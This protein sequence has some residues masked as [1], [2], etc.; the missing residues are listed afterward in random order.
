MGAPT[1]PV[2]PDAD[3]D[4]EHPIATAW[5]PLFA[6]VV[7]ALVRRDPT[8]LDGLPWLSPVSPATWEQMVEYVDD[9]GETLVALDERTW[10]TSV[11]QW[12]GDHWEV[13]V[14]LVTAE[15]GR[16]DMVLHAMVRDD[17]AGIAIETCCV[18]VP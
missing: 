2:L 16:S 10:E 9:Y 7:D 8:A 15:S 17:D 13:L 3:P 18:H 12:M 6:H 14:D 5:R 1:D 4:G 11:A